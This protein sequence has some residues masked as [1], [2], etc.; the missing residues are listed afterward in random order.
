MT[1]IRVMIVDESRFLRS[2]LILSLEAEADFQVVGEFGEGGLA[3]AEL[4]QLAPQVILLSVSLPDVSGFEACM[5][6]LDT[7]PQTR[8]IMLSPRLNDE[9]LATAIMAGAAAYLTKDAR[10]SD[11]IRTVRA[12]GAGEI[13]LVAP[14]AE[15]VLRAQQYSRR[16]VNVSQLTRREKQ[17]LVLVADGLSNVQ[18]GTRLALSPNTVRAHISH[19]FAKL[20]I[21]GRAELGVYLV[22]PGVLDMEDT[23]D[24]E[25]TED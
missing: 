20:K 3:I 22:L 14:V 7:A 9:E 11:L 25:D 5:R 23:E 16:M 1:L 13:F 21:S 15:R 12:N 24:T 2:G 18:I 19:I 6:I 17:V 10:N 4:E 8:V